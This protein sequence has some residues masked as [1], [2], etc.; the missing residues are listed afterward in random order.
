MYK[1]LVQVVPFDKPMEHQCAG[2]TRMIL[3]ERDEVS[4][5]FRVRF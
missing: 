4:V 5:L 1:L 3:A 2:E